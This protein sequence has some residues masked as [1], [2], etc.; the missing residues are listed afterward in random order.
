MANNFFYSRGIKYIP[1]DFIKCCWFFASSSCLNY[2]KCCFIYCC[3]LLL[4]FHFAS[5]TCIFFS[6]LLQYCAQTKKKILAKKP[7]TL[8]LSSIR[9][10]NDYNGC[11]LLW[12]LL[13]VFLFGYFFFFLFFF[14]FFFFW[15]LLLLFFPASFTQSMCDFELKNK[16]LLLIQQ[17]IGW[18]WAVWIT[19]QHTCSFTWTSYMHTSL[20]FFWQLRKY[21]IT[22]VVQCVRLAS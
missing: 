14:G 21:K 7:F 1:W 5:S 6:L 15:L 2:C 8:C 10:Q 3:A 4:I 11:C 19:K 16:K 20:H 12:L 18:R 13:K 9:C 17:W 22:D